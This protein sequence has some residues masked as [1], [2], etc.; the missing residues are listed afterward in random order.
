MMAPFPCPT[1]SAWLAETFLNL[2]G[3][4]TGA[5]NLTGLSNGK[6]ALFFQ[7]LRLQRRRKDQQCPS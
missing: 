6:V 4:T 2:F 3:A 7:W 5:F 1:L